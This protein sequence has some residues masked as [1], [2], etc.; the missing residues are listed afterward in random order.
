[1]GKNRG[2]SIAIFINWRENEMILFR[3]SFCHL[4][5]WLCIIIMMQNLEIINK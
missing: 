4:V 1:M 3:Y 5:Y 2:D